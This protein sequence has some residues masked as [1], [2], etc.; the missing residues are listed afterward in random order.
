MVNITDANVL[1]IGAGGIGCE[2]IKNLALMKVPS[3]TVVD[4]DTVDVSN[5]NRQFLFRRRHV[6]KPKAEVAAEAAL[7]LNPSLNITHMCVNVKT[8]DNT[9][10]SRFDVVMSALDNVD[11]RRYLNRL[12]L[13]SGVPL[14][15]AG[16]TGYMGQSRVILK[17]LTECYECQKK[18][19]P[20]VYPVCTIRSSPSTPV[21]CI[22]W[23]KL[24]YDLLFGPSSDDSSIIQDMH[25]TSGSAVD[26]LRHLFVTDILSQCELVDKWVD[27]LAPVPL[28]LSDYSDKD[29]ECMQS[30]SI[31]EAQKVLPIKSYISMFVS[32][33]TEILTN[34]SEMM[35][36]LQFTKD[37]PIAVDFVASASVLRMYNYHIPLLSRWDV[38]SIAGAIV[39]AIATTNAIVAGLQCSNLNHA[40]SGLPGRDLWVRYPHPSGNGC[41]I[42]SSAP[43]KPN[44]DCFICQSK[45]ITVLVSDYS[46]CTL[47]TFAEQM[48]R[49]TGIRECTIIVNNNLIFDSLEDEEDVLAQY[50]QSLSE[51][52]FTTSGQMIQ[53]EDVNT[54]ETIH[55]CVSEERTDGE[56]PDGDVTVSILNVKRQRVE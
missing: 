31:T 47:Q 55:M 44:P 38:E 54:S 46:K 43:A 56:T 51:W 6:G 23:A 25:M 53:V 17:D 32:S 15:E 48:V 10:V 22:Q 33:V 41:I 12:C 42:Q 1:V 16:S 29:F 26:Y 3:I 52:G 14:I 45:M 40:L 28:D 9:F 35:G 20:K 4:M 27:R 7:R 2:L 37:D 30:P 49:E 5:L 8:F 39:P 36:Q 34:R 13:A 21:H 24:L 11:A 19:A 50:E 18:E